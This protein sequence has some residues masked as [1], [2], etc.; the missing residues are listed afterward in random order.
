MKIV[1]ST[2]NLVFQPDRGRQID[3]GDRALQL[4]TNPEPVPNGVLASRRF[5]A[6]NTTTY[7]RFLVR[8]GTVGTGSDRLALFMGRD[9]VPILSFALTPDPSQ[10]GFRL[11]IVPG[12]DSRGYSGF[13]SSAQLVVGA[14]Y[15]VVA[16]VQIPSPQNVS[17][18][19][20]VNPNAVLADNGS[21]N[22]QA[23]IYFDSTIVFN[24]AGFSIES[25]DTGG[26]SSRATFDEL[27]IGYTW[28]DVVPQVR[29]SLAPNVVVSPAVQVAWHSLPD[30]TYQVQASYDRSSWFDVGDPIQGTG[31]RLF[32]FDPSDPDAEKFYRVRVR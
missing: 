6:Q 32:I 1:D 5:A 23:S 4:S 29:N 8:P 7:V 15:L 12:S 28:K 13:G 16:R 26:P 3:G 19:L 10:D 18:D 17:V 9:G 21:P 30:K 11:D 31:G 25:R 20:W 14:T 24:S 2:P 27:R 22:W